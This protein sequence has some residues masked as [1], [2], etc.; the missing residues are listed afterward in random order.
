MD[1]IVSLPYTVHGYNAIYTIVDQSSKLNRFI[2]CK[3]N[4]NAEGSACLFFLALDLSIWNA[5]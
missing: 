4:V 2:P 3:N 1:W 5:P